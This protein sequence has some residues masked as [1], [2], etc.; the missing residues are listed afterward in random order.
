MQELTKIID[1]DFYISSER[2]K[3]ENKMLDE[4]INKSL[5]W[6]ERYTPSVKTLNANGWRSVFSART[7]PILEVGKY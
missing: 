6:E 1:K 7:T 2:V 3:H 4:V 5:V